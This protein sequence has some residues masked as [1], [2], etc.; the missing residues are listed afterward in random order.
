MFPL[1]SYSN[2]V[3][4]IY[5]QSTDEGVKYK[6]IPI[7]NDGDFKE[8]WPEGFFGERLEELT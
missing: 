7:S 5:I 4:V 8:K 3:E 6:S 1:Y 2:D